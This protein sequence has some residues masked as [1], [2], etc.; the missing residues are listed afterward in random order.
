MTNARNVRIAATDAEILAC[1]AVMSELRP[2]VPIGEFVARVRRQ[3]KDGYRLA[4]LA[5]EDG[6][7]VAAAGYR[8]LENLAWGLFLYVD[9]LVTDEKFRSKGH[10]QKLFD[11]LVAEARRAGC[12]Q[13]HLDSGVFRHGAHRF[14]LLRRMDITSYHFAMKLGPG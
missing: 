5:G 2:H 8:I 12:A 9:D 4:Y 3:E 11:W 1:H 13:F 6:R 7:P 14:Y 10:G